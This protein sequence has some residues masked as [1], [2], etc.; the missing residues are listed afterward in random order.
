MEVQVVGIEIREDGNIEVAF[1]DTVKGKAVRGRF[2]HAPATAGLDHFAEHL[3]DLGRF[4]GGESSRVGEEPIGD[5]ALGGTDEAGGFID[6]REHVVEQMR[7]AGLA[8]GARHT[9]RAQAPSRVPGECCRDP[10][11]CL[12]R[13]RHDEG[14]CPRFAEKR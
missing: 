1:I 13:V 6:R 10:G 3:L 9:D 14:G 12:A 4:R 5:S 2:D 11:K 8:I 7:D